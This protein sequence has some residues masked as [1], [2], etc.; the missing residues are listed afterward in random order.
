MGET[1]AQWCETR[2]VRLALETVLASRFGT[3]PPE[4]A[5]AVASASRE[6]LTA[7]VRAAAT[8]PTLADVGI[9]RQTGS[10]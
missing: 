2:G 1:M 9:G 8:A 6:T 10:T 3:I 7:W 5:E 4:V